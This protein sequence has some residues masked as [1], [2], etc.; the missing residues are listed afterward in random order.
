MFSETGG[1]DER[2]DDG[3]EKRAGESGD[4]IETDDGSGLGPSQSHALQVHGGEKEK[5]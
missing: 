2:C 4:V 1:N 5:R 3:V